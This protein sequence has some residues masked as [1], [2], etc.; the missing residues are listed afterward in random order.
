M[1]EEQQEERNQS[2]RPQLVEKRG[3]SHPDETC[4]TEQSLGTKTS[5]RE[6]NGALSVLFLGSSRCIRVSTVRVEFFGGAET[7]HVTGSEETP[8]SSQKEWDSHDL[9]R[10]DFKVAHYALVLTILTVFVGMD[11]LLKKCKGSR[12]TKVAEMDHGRQTLP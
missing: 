10:S 11:D 5:G 4:C 7:E 9:V 2:S 1:I 3:R 6:V 12:A 8:S